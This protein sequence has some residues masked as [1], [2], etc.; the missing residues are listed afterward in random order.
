MQSCEHRQGA[1]LADDLVTGSGP[2]LSGTALWRSL[3]YPSSAAFR[4]AKARGKLEVKV[5]NLPQRRGT[6]AFTREVADWLR[7]LD[8]EEPM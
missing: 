2:F 1:S 3:G 6:F 5:F 4:Q 7:K 8:Q